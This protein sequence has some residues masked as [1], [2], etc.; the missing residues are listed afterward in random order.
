MNPTGERHRSGLCRRGGGPCLEEDARG[1]LGSAAA[2]EQAD[3]AVQVDV[4][5]SRELSRDA[6]LVAGALEPLG[7]PA[8]D[9]LGLGLL[10]F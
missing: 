9:P 4:D 5:A 8:D 3:R 1:G 2:L 10:E 6:R 7:A